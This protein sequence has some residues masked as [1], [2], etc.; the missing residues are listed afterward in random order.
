M[1][2]L[3]LDLKNY[4]EMDG[5]DDLESS[6]ICERTNFLNI[7]F[8]SG[9][10]NVQVAVPREVYGFDVSTSSISQITDWVTNNIVA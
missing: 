5:F 9:K 6:S 4:I 7:S 8:S 2:K 1:E 3:Y 10:G